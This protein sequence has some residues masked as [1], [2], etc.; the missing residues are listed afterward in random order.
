M[1]SEISAAERASEISVAKRTSEISASQ[2]CQE[3]VPR[4]F[5]RPI[6]TRKLLWSNCAAE[7]SAAQCHPVFSVVLS[8]HGS[9]IS[10]AIQVGKILINL[11]STF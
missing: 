10:E 8:V 6:S 7:I 11:N 9:E 3:I 5:L 4:K 2:Q 1:I